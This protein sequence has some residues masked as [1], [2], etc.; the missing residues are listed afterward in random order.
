MDMELRPNQIIPEKAAMPTGL[1]GNLFTD[2][3]FQ[4][5]CSSYINVMSD[6]V[7]IRTIYS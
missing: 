3:L 4:E 2:H 7:L 6:H 5:M 1:Y